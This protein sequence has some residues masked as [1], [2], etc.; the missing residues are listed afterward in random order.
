MA[1]VNRK[2]THRR[3]GGA[4]C[5]SSI[6]A[7]PQRH[8]APYARSTGRIYSPAPYAPQSACRALRGPVSWRTERSGS[9][10]A[11]WPLDHLTAPRG[12]ELGCTHG[13]P[14]LMQHLCA[15]RRYPAVEGATRSASG[16]HRQS[17]SAAARRARQAQSG[18]EASRYSIWYSGCRLGAV[19]FWARHRTSA[20][21]QAGCI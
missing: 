4:G 7:N 21:H 12:I 11:G 9:S 16:R 19:Q 15:S 8:P 1:T 6:R 2:T 10:L 14:R 3:A 5:W 13:R 17:K 18:R 20:A